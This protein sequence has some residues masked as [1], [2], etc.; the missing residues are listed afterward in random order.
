MTTWSPEV[1]LLWGKLDPKL[2]TWMP[3]VQHLEDSAD[4]AGVL[5]DDWLA[6]SLRNRLAD[7]FHGEANAR[8]VVRFL[9]GVH[10][11]GKAAPDFQCKEKS[12]PGFGFLSRSLERA[13]FR[14]PLRMTPG[15]TPHG[16]LGQSAAEDLLRESGVNGRFT[17]SIAGVIGS[18]HGLGAP[19]VSSEFLPGLGTGLWQEVRR[20][21]WATMADRVGLVDFPAVFDV[22]V[23]AWAQVELNGLVVMADWMASNVDLF[24]YVVGDPQVRMER[25][26]GQVEFPDRWIPGASGLAPEDLFAKQFPHLAGAQ[27]SP[28]Q[29]AAV[30]A[31]RDAE[32]PCLLVL[33]APTGDGKTE[34]ALMAASILA[35]RFGQG[36]VMVALPT[37]ATSN[38]MFTRVNRWLG[39]ASL[40]GRTS[41]AL[42]HGKASLNEDYSAM[43]AGRIAGVEDEA[44]FA[45][46]E[47][48]EVYVA[49]WFRG[50]RR[51]VLSSHVV[52][53]IDQVLFGGLRAKHTMLRQLALAGKVVVIDE[54]HAADDYMRVYLTRTLT[55]LAHHRVPVVLLSATLPPTVRAE[56]AAAYARGDSGRR[57]GIDLPADGSYP[58]ITR[59]TSVAE[60]IHVDGG[61]DGEVR[62]RRVLSLDDD[63]DR[64]VDLLRA[65][66]VDGGCAVVISST[67]RRAQERYRAV[68]SAGLGE[69]VLIHSKFIAPHRAR[70][71]ADL[72][73]RL[74]PRGERP[75]RLI[76]IATQVVEQSLDVDFDLMV[77][78]VAPL[79]L[80][81][82]RWG[83]LHRHARLDRP[84][85]LRDARCY[86]TGV[87]W[88]G[89]VPDFDP[90]VV[91]VYRKWRPFSALAALG[92]LPRTVLVP[93]E[94]PGLVSIAYDED[95]RP[96]AGWEGQWARA[97]EQ[98]QAH[99]EDQRVRAGAFVVDDPSS[100][101][102]LSRWAEVPADDPD[103]PRN[104]KAAVRDT[105]ES[106]EVILVQGDGAGNACLPHGIGEFSGATLPRP[107]GE[108]DTRLAKAAASCTVALPRSITASPATLD[109][110]LSELENYDAAEWQSSPWLAGELFLEVDRAGRA[111]LAGKVLVYD[112]ELG[113]RE[114]EA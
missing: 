49:S 8:A 60:D 82:Q 16:L 114:E 17:V 79:D 96:P 35:E 15:L 110:A 89:Q 99:R 40:S 50:R 85:R 25:A 75:E 105:D 10:D 102:T 112:D 93:D 94:V 71:E 12:V 108:R 24:P 106:L 11:L 76:V 103:S 67:V 88:K 5:F 4:I 31:A 104:A 77:S 39:S 34:A 21:I 7:H 27:P 30:T 83:R 92:D 37:M 54:V 84:D 55:W 65:E 36:G 57:V 111:A 47:S 69:V 109:A 19:S 28:L 1:R 62:E 97:L 22:A 107:L 66:L 14:F 38:P 74:G 61:G 6:L 73:S 48:A 32:G 46:G 80:L 18:H 33:E 23:P 29:R 52:G 91:A 101:W 113:L 56:L 58:R 78:D 44:S 64:L 90:G 9:A 70:R 43:A 63:V 20:E 42:V 100:F 53:T 86:I 3:L 98:E 13:G 95:R 51:A 2:G 41:L 59:V 45:S 72:V 81:V 68:K 87:D 26:V